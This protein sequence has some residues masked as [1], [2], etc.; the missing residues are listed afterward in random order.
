MFRSV[1]HNLNKHKT[2]MADVEVN[3]S[4][5]ST[6][7]RMMQ[8]LSLYNAVVSSNQSAHTFSVLRSIRFVLN[9]L[10]A[11]NSAIWPFSLMKCGYKIEDYL[12]FRVYI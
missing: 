5:K 10:F 9:D 8:G 11:V 2:V 3:A 7:R 4:A 12:R 6:F 1:F